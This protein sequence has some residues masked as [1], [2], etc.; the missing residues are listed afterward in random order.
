MTN[1]FGLH[2]KLAM[3]E[4]EKSVKRMT[5]QEKDM[6]ILE[7]QRKLEAFQRTQGIGRQDYPVEDVLGPM[8]GKAVMLKVCDA[9][10]RI[11]YANDET[12]FYYF[13]FYQIEHY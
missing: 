4:Q 10:F 12:Y 7:Q 1:T 5:E 8:D 11:S 13:I 6:L 2:V 9:S 3:S